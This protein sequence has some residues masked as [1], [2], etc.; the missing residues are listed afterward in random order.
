MGVGLKARS[1]QKIQG[2]SWKYREGVDHRK[3][4]VQLERG[5]CKVVPSN[6]YLAPHENLMSQKNLVVA[7]Y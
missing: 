4:G 3:R 5:G 7:I 6:D 1:V 2:G